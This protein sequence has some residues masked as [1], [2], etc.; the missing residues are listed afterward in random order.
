MRNIP[1]GRQSIDD[2]DVESVCSVLR[3]DWLT[4]GPKVREF[5]EAL[6]EECGAKYC[7]LVANGTMALELACLAI[8][9]SHGKVGLAS[10]IS[11]MASALSKHTY[12][13]LS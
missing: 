13:I 2:E 1:Y 11:L 9:I 5:E 7:I 4:Q 6:C 12:I 3:S 10:P 8:D